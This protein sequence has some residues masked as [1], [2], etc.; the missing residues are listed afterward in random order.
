MLSRLRVLRAFV[1]CFVQPAHPLHDALWRAES[2]EAADLELTRI[3]FDRLP[4]LRQRDIL[5]SY[6]EHWRRRARTA[7]R[8]AADAEGL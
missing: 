6:A 4:A 1:Q 3:E 2:G 5:N 8:R 7:K